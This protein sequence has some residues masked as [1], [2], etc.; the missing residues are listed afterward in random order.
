M[1][2]LVS[3]IVP[4]FNR[5]ATIE[6][7]LD[8][9]IKQSYRNIEIIVVDD[10]SKDRTADICDS[11]GEKDGRVKVFHNEN[12]GVSYSRNYGLKHMTGKYVIF[13]DSDDY[14]NESYIEHL[15]D[16]AEKGGL[17]LVVGS[18]VIKTAGKEE[19]FD[20]NRYGANAVL[21]HD[22]Y[23]LQKFMGGYGENC[24]AAN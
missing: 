9:I 14:I 21:N 12:Y 7:C 4:V 18:L 5:E 6:R 8:S 19:R 20:M 15:V 10:G 1:N 13:V 17:A 22:Y 16:Q 2:K 11:Y 3:V 23:A 24:I